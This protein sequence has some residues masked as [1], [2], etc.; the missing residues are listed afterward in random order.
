VAIRP[1]PPR[2]DIALPWDAP[3]ADVVATMAGARA[4]GG[5]TFVVDSGGVDHLF[6]FSPEGVR[7]F[8]ALPEAEASKGVADWQMLLRKLPP[9]LF[10]GRRTLPHD[11]FGREDAGAHLAALDAA[12]DEELAVLGEAGEV[13]VFALTRRLGHR[14]GLAAWGGTASARGERFTAL[15]EALDELDGSDAFV[16]PGEMAAVAAGDHARERAAMARAEALLGETLAERRDQPVDDLLGRIIE[17]WDG[18]D[19]GVARDVILVHLGSMSNL[20]AALGW[21]I[22]DLLLHPDVQARVRGGEDGLLERC[23]L[24]STR[25]AQR[26]IMLRAVLRPTTVADETSTWAVEPGD[27]VATFLPLTNTSAMP[28]L[29]RYDPDRWQR[30]RLRD[31]DQLAAR[32]LVTTFGHGR[33]TCPAMPFS[34]AAMTR[35]VQRLLDAHDLDAGFDQARPLPGQI[36]GV[37][38][39]D[40]P[41]P[42]RYSAR[43]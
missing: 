33:H 15:V 23:A 13:D 3:V 39:A 6:L 19:Q 42:M 8:Y 18:D 24:E 16:H 26:S 35:S 11:L 25:L 29:E 40:G 41:C 31:E 38:R 32:E 28:G 37:A 36:G 14:M 21:T 10:D 1:E 5:D 17:R 9:E 2:A 4:R 34:L 12:I 7:S 43:R 22:V 30:R 20:F 27:V